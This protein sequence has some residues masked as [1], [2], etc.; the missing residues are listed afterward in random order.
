MRIFNGKLK[1]EGDIAFHF[2]LGMR[3]LLDRL[4]GMKILFASLEDDNSFFML[5]QEKNA[6]GFEGLFAVIPNKSEPEP[7][8]FVLIPAHIQGTLMLLHSPYPPPGLSEFFAEWL[9][10]LL[11]A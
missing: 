7:T 5:A 10:T 11:A 6:K 9:P 2:G 3:S 8:D 4:D 1:D